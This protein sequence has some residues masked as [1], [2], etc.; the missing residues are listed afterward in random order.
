MIIFPSKIATCHA[1]IRHD[2]LVSHVETT[3][4]HLKNMKR[5]PSTVLHPKLRNI[6]LHNVTHSLIPQNPRERIF[7]VQIS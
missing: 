1:H 6:N 2:A 7:V 3:L 4:Q 5:G